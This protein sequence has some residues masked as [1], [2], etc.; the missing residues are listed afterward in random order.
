MALR[1]LCRDEQQRTIVL[2]ANGY[3]LT[4]NYVPLGSESI[5]DNTFKFSNLSPPRC[6]VEFAAADTI[7]VSKFRTLG[8]GLGTLGLIKLATGDVFICIITRSTTVANVRPRETVQRIDNVEFFC[9][10]RPDYDLVVGPDS[11]TRNYNYGTA[12]QGY[13]VAPENPSLALKKLL[14]DGS[15]FYSSDFNLTERIQDRVDDPVAFDIESLDED[16]LWNSYMIKPL[17][18]FRNGLG[19]QDRQKLDSSRLLTSAIRGFAQSLTIPASSSLFPNIESNLPSS[20]TVISRL[21]SRRAG[22]RFN[23]RG[24]D[25]DGNVANFVETETILWIPPALC[26]SY[27]QVRGSVPVFWEQEAGYIPGAQKVKVSR[28][29][30]AA[31]LAFD[32]HFGDLTLNYGAV[33]AINL[34]ARSKE[35]EAELTARYMY[36]VRGS[37]LY[38]KPGSG[39][40]PGHDLLKMTEYDFHA[41]TKGPAGY[42]AASRIKDVIGDSV[43]GFA[44]FLSEEPAGRES[45]LSTS[46]IRLA[47]QQNVVLQQDGVFR[48]NC[49]DCLD[50]TNLIQTMISRMVI[51]MFLAQRNGHSP[52]DFWM[53]HSTLWADNGDVLSRIYAGTGALKSSF[54]RHGAMSVAGQFADFRKSATRLFVNNFTDPGTQT[55]IDTLLGLMT[56]QVPVRL[57]DPI[58]D[59]VDAE[60]KRNAAEFTSH[61]KI[62]IWVGTFNINGCSEGASEDLSPWL[63]GS[64]EKLGEEPT[65]VG[66]GFQ[67]IVALSPQ[68][69]MSTDPST[70]L[71]WEEAVAKSL[72]DRAKQRGTT[73]YVF[74]RSG[75]LVGAALILFVKEDVIEKIKNVEG[76]VKKTGLSGMGGNKGA[77]AV[78]M[79]YCNTRICF[80]TAHLAAGFSNYEE[81]NRDYQTIAR[82]LRFQRNRT[83]NDHDVIIWFGDFNYRIGLSNER[84]NIQM[85]AGMAFQFYMEGPITFPPTYRYDN[86]TDLYDTSEKQRIPAWCDRILWKGS[87]L[88]QLAYHTAPLKFSDHR[89][90]YA[91]F[92]CEIYVVDEKRKEEL[93]RKLYEAR[94]DMPIKTPR[95]LISDD[96]EEEDDFDDD[97]FDIEDEFP[98][99]PGL[100]PPSSDKQKWWIDN[101]R[102]VRSTIS[103]PLGA[104][105]NVQR[106]A[107]PFSTSLG[108][109]WSQIGEGEIPDYTT[110]GQMERSS[111]RNSTKHPLSPSI[112]PLRSMTEVIHEQKPLNRSAS[113]RSGTMALD[114]SKKPPPP[115]PKK[116]ATLSPTAGMAKTENSAAAASN[117]MPKRWTGFET[118]LPQPAGQPRNGQGQTDM[119]QADGTPGSQA[120]RKVVRVGAHASSTPVVKKKPLPP[121][122]E[123]MDADNG[124]RVPSW[125]PLCPQK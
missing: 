49:L 5:S 6:V 65:I 39:A 103:P 36:H 112:L 2:V 87:N 45:E 110:P 54:T 41:E 96:Q 78:R 35:A 70:R 40:A 31:Q 50:R 98:V 75:Q 86:G 56:E 21:S 57:F 14:D 64:L 47:R 90:V 102:P 9:L 89:P 55:T 80:I 121:P 32:K 122:N 25:D 43:E 100:P 67:E 104:R 84:L 1:V 63:H 95:C 109:D 83:I 113:L 44:Y 69:I 23:A 16:F 74:L 88:R 105:S 62:R 77:C 82:G 30:A 106:G 99:A 108:S 24:I 125:E 114:G 37:P 27:T 116:P 117:N 120:P 94:K 10:N 73:K 66:V 68:Q 107:N 85:V 46:D 18:Q 118:T 119:G 13:D 59:M 22:T 17:L 76:S 15:F 19:V 28:A 58:K 42:E 34:L 3:A 52:R 48:T 11:D 93:G 29:A 26:F 91:V 115:V 38:R 124:A 71:I 123:L 79:E 81:R 33:H 7:P 53:R 4:I 72:N 97:H 51:E 61:E 8:T 92:E 101:G 12:Y 20:L 60:L 111:S